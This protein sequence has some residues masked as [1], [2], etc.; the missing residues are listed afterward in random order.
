MAAKEIPAIIIAVIVYMVGLLTTGNIPKGGF[1]CE[2]AGEIL[3]RN[4]ASRRIN[5]NE[6]NLGMNYILVMNEQREEGNS[7]NITIIDPSKK[8]NIGR[9]LNHSCDPNCEIRSVRVDC[10]I[11]KIA[12]FAKRDISAGEELC[13]H[14]NGGQI[15]KQPKFEGKTCLCGAVNCAGFMPFNNLLF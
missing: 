10:P 7:T 8:G 11:P 5:L 14:Y 2:Y 6:Q 13:F 15:E 9:Y 12:I 3:T 1:I 4:E